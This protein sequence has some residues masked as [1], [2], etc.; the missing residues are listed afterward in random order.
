MLVL[1]KTPEVVYG[2]IVRQ[3]QA[4]VVVK[5]P[6]ETGKLREQT[7]KRS[8]IA[9]I[10][11]TVSSARLLALDPKQ[12]A[13][14]RDYAEE[15]SAKQRDWEAR[16]TALR[17]YA[18]AFALDREQLG[19]SAL[20]GM[21]PLARSPQEE[22]RWT[23][24]LFMLDAKLQIDTLPSGKSS[25]ETKKDKARLDETLRAIQQLRRGQGAQARTVLAKAEIAKLLQSYESLVTRS[26]LESASK[27][28][29]LSD[30]RLRQILLLE[31]ALESQRVQSSEQVMSSVAPVWSRELRTGGNQPVPVI[32]GERL[33]EFDPRQSLFRDGKWIS[34]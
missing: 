33:T 18:I 6:D 12:P 9:E 29:A 25:A 8:E 11:E 30:H 13:A 20:R 7:F 19:K 27:E 4:Q 24:A 17:L 1:K 2:L 5:G 21:L 15:L 22:Q 32:D 23:A 28:A 3:D 34:P 10:I 26:E 14:Y 31:L 16:E